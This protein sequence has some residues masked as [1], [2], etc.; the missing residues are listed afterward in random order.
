MPT[1]ID[2]AHL[3]PTA[4]KV[5]VE[6]LEQ[7]G[8]L[9]AGGVWTLPQKGM[10]KDTMYGRV[11]RLGDAPTHRYLGMAPHVRESHSTP[12]PETARQISVGDIVVWP[13]DVPVAF[14]HREKRYA[15][16]LEHE[17]IMIAAV[18]AE[19]ETFDPRSFRFGG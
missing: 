15:I 1:E 17:A 6:V 8:G 12:W 19:A 18:A 4:G 13:R 5:I 3:A 7:L 16:C 14:V 10:A 2:P 9:S 11:L